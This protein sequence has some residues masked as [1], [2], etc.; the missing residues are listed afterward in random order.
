[1]LTQPMPFDPIAIGRGG[2]PVIN[3]EIGQ[4]QW[5]AQGTERLSRIPVAAGGVAEDVFYIK[6]EKNGCGDFNPV[7]M[8]QY[9]LGSCRLL[10]E[11]T[12]GI[13]KRLTN[14]FVNMDFIASPV[15]ALPCFFS[16]PLW[17]EA[18]TGLKVQVQQISASVANKVELVLHGRRIVDATPEQ[19][20]NLLQKAYLRSEWPVWLGLDDVLVTL[21]ANQV[22]FRT[23]ITVPADG[24]VQAEYLLVKSTGPVRIQ[25]TDQNGAPLLYGGGPI[26]AGGEPPNGVRSIHIAGSAIFPYRLPM[27]GWLNRQTVLNVFLT[28]L[29]AAENAVELCIVGR[30]MDY[31][32]GNGQLGKTSNGENYV[33]QPNQSAIDLAQSAANP[34]VQNPWEPA[35]QARPVTPAITTPGWFPG[36]LRK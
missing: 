18:K 4:L 28:D 12:G 30:C 34:L 32:E 15:G 14:G 17:L 31:P 36:W 19:R 3:P 11:A 20:K 16:T 22:G 26:A 10:L 2:L 8:S 29:S 23:N 9:S 7:F 25:I 1:M 24:D 33:E 6:P 21:T 35:R 27:G 13:A 5:W